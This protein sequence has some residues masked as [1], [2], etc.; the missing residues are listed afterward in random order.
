MSHSPVVGLI[1]EVVV[2]GEQATTSVLAK[3]DTGAKRTSIDTALA[4]DLGLAAAAESVTVRSSNGVEERDVYPFTV[5][6]CGE[7]HE[8]LASVTD[9]STMT[10]DVI[11]GRD[12]LN[13]YLVDPSA[14]E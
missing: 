5:E 10:Y 11:L 7:S 13:A 6:L 3:C 12:V 2:S 1:E 14:D 9:R 8:V 4:H